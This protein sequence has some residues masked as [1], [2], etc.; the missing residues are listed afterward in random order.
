MRT[1]DSSA[2]NTSVT[3][4]ADFA[5]GEVSASA[6]LP[7]PP[8][9]VFKAMTSAEICDWWVR[10]GV[11]DTREWT[12]DLR[13]GGRWE[14]AGIGGGQPYRLQGEYLDIAAPVRLVH[15]WNMIGKAGAPST[16]TYGVEARGDS[17]RL[18]VDHAGLPVEEVCE[19]TRAGWE[20]SLT[21]L[22]EILA[23]ERVAASRSGA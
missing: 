19:A 4:R 9:R 16:V 21:R 12:G 23:E 7:A 20:T 14:S 3:A 2:I 17:V 8:D 10:P 18:T 13:V 1:S 11:F 22:A 6:L 15:T 5:R